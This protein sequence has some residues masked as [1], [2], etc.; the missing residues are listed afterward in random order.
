MQMLWKFALL[1]DLLTVYRLSKKLLIVYIYIFLGSTYC[2][3]MIIPIDMCTS[4]NLHVNY[5]NFFWLMTYWI[6]RAPERQF[7][8]LFSLSKGYSNLKLRHVG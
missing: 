7:V 4:R 1:L 2:I 5:V 3:Y 6:T 8:F